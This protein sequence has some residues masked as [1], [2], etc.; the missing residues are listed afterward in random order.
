MSALEVFAFKGREVR[1][2]LV[3]GEP[4]FVL[5]D[6]CRALEIAN[7]SDTATRLDGDA[8]GTAEVIDSMGRPQQARTV[9]EQGLYDVVFLSR[10][11]EAREFQ[12]WVTGEVLPS[13]RRTGSYGVVQ[14]AELT[15]SDLA[16]MVLESEAE[17]AALAAKIEHDAPAVEYVD[18]FVAVDDDA[19][20]FRVASAQLSMGEHALR[21]ALLEAGWIHRVLIG[22][23]W[24][25]KAGRIVDE[26]EYRPSS[27]HRGKFTLR[28]QHNAPRHHNGQV[29]QTLY[30]LAASMPAIQRRV[31]TPALV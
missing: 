5:A 31:Q 12:R 29:R 22:Q 10:K 18:K 23:R 24:S 1:T 20:T 27:A 6:V 25:G 21:D 3:D 17:K 15:R 14:P 13:I 8:L 9:T 2:V 19:I 11:P 16:R 7:P 30:I 26:H 28:P 4:Q